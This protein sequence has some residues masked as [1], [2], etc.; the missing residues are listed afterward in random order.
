MII[1]CM[2]LSPGACPPS[3]RRSPPQY[4]S[5][6]ALWVHTDMEKELKEPRVQG[7]GV[8]YGD[9][10]PPR[11]VGNDKI[12]NCFSLIGLP[13]SKRNSVKRLYANVMPVGIG[14]PHFPSR[15]KPHPTHPSH[16]NPSTPPPSQKILLSIP[17][18]QGQDRAH[19]S[20]LRRH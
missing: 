13:S 14:K 17:P 8:A 20:K 1:F 10:S 5:K 18:M 19:G 12:K 6:G 3:Q 15:L 9:S 2:L 4:G 16:G 11:N 7:R